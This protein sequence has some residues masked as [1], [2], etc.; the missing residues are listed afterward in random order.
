MSGARYE[1]LT[2][3]QA[4]ERKPDSWRIVD[5]VLVGRYRSATMVGGLAFITDV[6]AAAEAA[7]HHPDIEFRYGTVAFALT[8]HAVGQLSDADV[9]MAHAI[10]AIADDHGIAPIASE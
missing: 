3:A 7:D 2:T 6:V 5:G 4:D 8:T 1:K 10:N 9:D